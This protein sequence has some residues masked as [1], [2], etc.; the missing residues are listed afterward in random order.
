L[1]ILPD[2]RLVTMP[3][4][5]LA[6]LLGEADLS[7]WPSADADAPS[8]TVTIKGLHWPLAANS[9]F[10]VASLDEGRRVAII[11]PDDGA[12]LDSFS[13]G[14][15]P[16]PGFLQAGFAGERGGRLVLLRQFLDE[17]WEAG[18]WA[19]SPE[20][21][22]GPRL[23]HIQGGAD[24]YPDLECP[25]SGRHFIIS[26]REEIRS[27]EV[28]SGRCVE[29]LHAPGSGTY[30]ARL[31]PDGAVVAAVVSEQSRSYA[32]WSPLRDIAPPGGIWGWLTGP[33]RRTPESTAGSPESSWAP[34]PAPEG[35]IMVVE[36]GGITARC[37]KTLAR[38]ASFR[39]ANVDLNGNT[40]LTPDGSVV[41]ITGAGLAVWPWR[42]LMGK[43]A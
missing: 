10:V 40:H 2:G 20:G 22:V 31:L 13:P 11:A 15:Q 16:D 24:Q 29:R 14:L 34:K 41:A 33:P 30:Y 8:W 21:R 36:G 42:E 37:A 27:Y 5:P 4:S 39:A 19:I 12:V 25:P 38:R 35:E 6:D 9:T 3:N 17:K 1:Q 18:V 23:H 32:R 26:T 43:P 28:A 7:L